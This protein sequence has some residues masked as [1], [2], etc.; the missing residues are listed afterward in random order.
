MKHL[1]SL[2]QEYRQA[3]KLAR[4]VADAEAHERAAEASTTAGR[5]DASVALWLAASLAW[6]EIAG[7]SAVS[8]TRHR[9]VQR[10][11]HCAY[12]VARAGDSLG[13]SLL[14][15]A[16]VVACGGMN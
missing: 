4:A 10:S 14:Y 6:R 3:T 1:L 13:H 16:E 5:H 11:M 2:L 7:M 9:V 12:E 15:A 8:S